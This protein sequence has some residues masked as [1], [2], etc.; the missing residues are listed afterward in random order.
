M[1]KDRVTNNEGNILLDICKSNNLVILNGRCGDDK[2]VGA[3]TFRNCSVIDYSI[4]SYQSLSHVNNFRIDEVDNLFS[5]GHSLL[6]TE[7]NFDN[8]LKN[9]SKKTC[10]QNQSKPRW[11][12]EQKS[13]FVNN[14]DRNK[15]ADLHSFILDK[16]LNTDTI[17]KDDINTICG[18]ISD[19]FSDSASVS[20]SIKIN[21]D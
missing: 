5:D 16:N 6:T 14:L 13:N 17:T 18:T 10:K 1:S 21:S 7:L 9:A 12:L 11:K 8:K 15:I 3:T 2:Y 19:I 20:M 4:A